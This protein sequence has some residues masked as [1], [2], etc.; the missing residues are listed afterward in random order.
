MRQS[1]SL[2]Y[3]ELRMTFI[4]MR[5]D[6]LRKCSW[7]PCVQGNV[8]CMGPLV[9]VEFTAGT[10][11]PLWSRIHAHPV[12]PSCWGSPKSTAKV[13]ARRLES[14]VLVPLVL[15][16]GFSLLGMVT[17]PPSPGLSCCNVRNGGQM[18]D[19]KISHHKGRLQVQTN[20]EPMPGCLILF[21]PWW[22]PAA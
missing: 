17:I 14:W 1:L 6:L 3:K 20:V 22:T 21:C 4:G 11:P 13:A 10:G 19:T 8:G 12:S 9:S 18:P 7:I 16:T 5:G 2:F 15:R